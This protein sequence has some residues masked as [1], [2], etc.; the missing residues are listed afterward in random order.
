MSQLSNQTTLIYGGDVVTQNAK[1]EIHEAMVTK[2]GKVVATGSYD[3]MSALAGAGAR[4]IDVKGNTVIPGLIDNHP[5]AMH[6]AGWDAGCVWLY[7][8]EDHAEIFK[9]IKERVAVTPKGQWILTTPVGEVHY[10]LRRNF[11]DLKEGRLPNRWELDKIAP[12]NPVWITS[13]AP[14]EPNCTAMNS[15]ALKRLGFDK[16]LPDFLDGVHIGKDEHG[17]LTGIFWGKV[18][19]YYN[20]SYK[21]WLPRVVFSE[22]SGDGYPGVE[23][24][25]YCGLRGQQCAASRG[26]TSVLEGHAMHMNNVQA[27]IDL[28]NAGLLR[29]RTIVSPEVA[30]TCNDGGLSLSEEGIVAELA[31]A[32]AF[33]DP[34]DDMFS[35]VGCCLPTGEAV[36]PGNMRW[37]FPYPDQ[38][39]QMTN[40]VRFCT[41]EWQK[42]IYEYCMDNKLRLNMLNLAWPDHDEFFDM[43]EKNGW[44]DRIRELD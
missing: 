29:M 18:N 8:C 14:V 34:G 23:A 26:V 16:T 3:D 4:K 40:G 35:V 31:R 28:H 44:A 32:L 5:H 41:P 30:L 27:Y 20:M 43:V 12:D 37:G 24:W 38:S 39:G 6:Y 7:D 17:E 10:F 22:A 11:K 15:L 19:R 33:Q 9:R 21:F 25:K 42:M 2:D 1:R 36:W 13:L